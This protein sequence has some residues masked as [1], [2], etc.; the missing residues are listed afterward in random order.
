MCM[1]YC[2]IVSEQ[3][4]FNFNFLGPFMIS[5]T[6]YLNVGDGKKKQ[7]P[8]TLFSIT[9]RFSKSSKD[10]LFLI[11]FWSFQAKL[12]DLLSLFFTGLRQ[13]TPECGDFDA[14]KHQWQNQWQNPPALSSP[15]HSSFHLPTSDYF[16]SKSASLG[17]GKEFILLR[18]R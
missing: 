7:N 17:P 1:I 5:E 14:S 2:V 15:L 10:N 13:S 16:Q 18:K 9:V 8:E 3:L 12:R 6:Y 4:S 11:L